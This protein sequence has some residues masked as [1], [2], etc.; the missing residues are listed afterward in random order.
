M[1]SEQLSNDV[2]GDFEAAQAVIGATQDG[3][4]AS[5]GVREVDEEFNVVI[6][7][8]HGTVGDI[9][10]PNTTVN[11]DNV[12]VSPTEHTQAV[13]TL[14]NPDNLSERTMNR[15]ALLP[16]EQ[17]DK[18]YRKAVKQREI[19]ARRQNDPERRARKLANQKAY[20]AKRRQQGGGQDEER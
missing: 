12:V 19:E 13:A 15:L 18:A 16:P 17:F 11:E 2:V 7:D 6:D 5:G 3:N 20:D 4:A 10:V 14:N 1:D 9:V 8:I